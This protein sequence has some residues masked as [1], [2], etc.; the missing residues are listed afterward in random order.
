M[1]YEIS[2]K[3][4]LHYFGAERLNYLYSFHDNLLSNDARSFD[5]TGNASS[6]LPW[7]IFF[8][9]SNLCYLCI[10]PF[11][12]LCINGSREQTDKHI[13]ELCVKNIRMVV[14]IKIKKIPCL[15]FL[16]CHMLGSEYLID[17]IVFLARFFQLG[18]YIQLC[19]KMKHERQFIYKF[20]T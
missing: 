1:K 20:V 7:V 3:I 17:L 11:P 13:C 5:I 9:M 15:A 16:R 14:I 19:N 8:Q 18:F 2:Y 12:H 6:F 4:I 10:L